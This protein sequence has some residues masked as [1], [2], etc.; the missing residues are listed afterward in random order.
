MQYRM[1]EEVMVFPEM[2]PLKAPVSHWWRLQ[3]P[4]DQ[5]SMEGGTERAE[6]KP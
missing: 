4:V 3:L 1:W 5:L 2:M 6:Q